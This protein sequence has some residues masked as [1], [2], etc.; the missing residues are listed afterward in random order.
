MS[1]WKPAQPGMTCDRDALGW[2]E[3]SPTRC[4]KPAVAFLDERCNCG[5]CDMTIRHCQ[6]H[7]DKWIGE[8][9]QKNEAARKALFGF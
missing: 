6:E 3:T 7:H 5:A 1:E 8:E 2:S 9:Q 4:G